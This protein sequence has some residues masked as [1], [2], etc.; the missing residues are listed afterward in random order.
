MNIQISSMSFKLLAHVINYHIYSF[1]NLKQKGKSEH[2][3]LWFWLEISECDLSK[4]KKW[5]GVWCWA[6]WVCRG[7]FFLASSHKRRKLEGR[8]RRSDMRVKEVWMTSSSLSTLSED[9]WA[10]SGITVL[11]SIRRWYDIQTT[12]KINAS[13][14][15][16][17]A[18]P[19]RPP[20]V[21]K[22][23]GGL[24]NTICGWSLLYI[25][26]SFFLTNSFRFNE[27]LEH[28]LI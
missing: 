23:F 6:F 3:L 27:Y 21:H 9:E 4:V 17:T 18:S 11:K 26:V 14:D 5:T 10:L 24:N 8:G 19:P 22:S 7:V 13:E 25:V 1:T 20:R 15:A 28:Y 12:H 16:G 2:K